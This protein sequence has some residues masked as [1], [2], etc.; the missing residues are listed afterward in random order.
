MP[1]CAPKTGQFQCHLETQSKDFAP[2]KPRA[3]KHCRQDARLGR[4]Q[5]CTPAYLGSMK[6][7]MFFA[8]FP[9]HFFVFFFWV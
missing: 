2:T 4:H 5:M 7:N 1:T 3:R 6:N 8:N 9:P